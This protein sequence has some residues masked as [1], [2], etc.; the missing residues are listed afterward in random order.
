MQDYLNTGLLAPRPDLMAV[1]E[2]RGY[3][4]TAPRKAVAELLEQKHDGFTVEA[5]SEEL[6]SVGGQ[7]YTG[8]SN[9]F[10]KREWSA[11]SP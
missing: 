6:P 2:N 9:S 7:R 3:R 4:A 10:S 8:P 5:L 1:L 11:S